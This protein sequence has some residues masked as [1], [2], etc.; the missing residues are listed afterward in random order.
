M[1]SADR[2]AFALWNASVKESDLLVM[3]RRG[4]LVELHLRGGCANLRSV[5]LRKRD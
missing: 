2:I 4:R 3:R 1:I 5:V